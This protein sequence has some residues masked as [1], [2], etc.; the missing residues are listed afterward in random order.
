MAHA[1]NGW[2]VRWAYEGVADFARSVGLPVDAVVPKR[3]RKPSWQP[4]WACPFA[5]AASLVSIV[6]DGR[7]GLYP[8][9]PIFNDLVECGADAILTVARAL[10]EDGQDAE[11]LVWKEPTAGGPPRSTFDRATKTWVAR[12]GFPDAGLHLD[13]GRRHLQ[14]WTRRPNTIRHWAPARWPG[15]AFASLEDRFEEHVALTP[16]R[17]VL[18]VPPRERVLRGI[19]ELL[20]TA[21]PRGIGYEGPSLDSQQRAAIVEGALRRCLARR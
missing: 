21:D 15:W 18:D 4:T 16:D 5:G 6:I 7:C 14:Y 17:I 8:L 10:D 11:K 1:W 12:P 19:A 9:R 20:A 13:V 3:D 2:E